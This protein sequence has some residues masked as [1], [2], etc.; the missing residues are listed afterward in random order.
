MRPPGVV[1]V[2]PVFDEYPCFGEGSE[3]GDVQ[4]LVSDPAIE[5]LDPRVLPRRAG[6]DVD[7]AETAQQAPVLQ[8]PSDQFGLSIRR[9]RGAL[10]SVTRRSTTATTSSPVIDRPTTI[11]LA[12]GTEPYSFGANMGN[13]LHLDTLYIIG[14]GDA[15]EVEFKSPLDFDGWDQPPPD[16]DPL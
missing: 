16:T 13:R 7:G 2:S 15:P 9:Y 4:Q 6:L 11:Y 10:R 8:D 5:R 12:A 14:E 1:F 3:F